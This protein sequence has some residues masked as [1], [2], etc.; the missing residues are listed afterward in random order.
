VPFDSRGLRWRSQLVVWLLMVAFIAVTAIMIRTF[1]D[2]RS[3]AIALLMSRDQ[4]LT[5]LSAARLRDELSKFANVLTDVARMQEIYEGDPTRQRETLQQ[6]PPVRQGIFDG[7]VILLN[8]FGEVVAAEPELTDLVGQDWSD[9]DY[10]RRMLSSTDAYFSNATEERFGGSQM[11]VI[12]VPVKGEGGQFVGVLAGMM[13]LGETT[14]SPLYATIVRLRLGQNGSSIYVLDG[15][16]TILFDSVGDEVGKPYTSASLPADALERKASAIRTL[17]SD[18][19][20]VIAT[21]APVPG[22]AWTLVVEDD[23]NVTTQQT[24]RY[25]GLLVLLFLSS[26]LLLGAGVAILIYQR[27]RATA[28]GRGGESNVQV[29]RQ[30]KETLLP[31]HMPVMPGWHISTHYE[32]VPAIDGDF[33]DLALLRDGRLMVVVGDINEVGVAVTTVLAVTRAT[34]R[35]AARSMLSPAQTLERTNDFL[36][37][38]LSTETHVTCSFAILDPSSGKLHGANAGPHLPA[39]RA[40]KTTEQLK[41]NGVPLGS[42]PG[43]V[44]EEYETVLAPGEWVLF[45]NNGLPEI[46]NAEGEQFGYVRLAEVLDQEVTGGE[47]LIEAIL[48]ALRSFAG[49]ASNAESSL[50]MVVV[51]RLGVEG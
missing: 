2:Y 5:F 1:L 4:Q 48:N 44:Y 7:G 34:L 12:S 36:F 16:G 19:N 14:I 21:F 40:G 25:L 32:P 18:Q 10:F 6:A 37:A 47:A 28:G 39:R 50:V 23:W 45:Y 33:Y 46:R 42:Q 22:T 41:A 9:R 15:D 13:R 38:E 35:G 20:E 49:D 3:A 27:N 30:I 11:V 26:I 51:E 43:T 8:N 17:D 31:E 29:A 24:Q